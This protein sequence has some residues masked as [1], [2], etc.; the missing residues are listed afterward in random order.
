MSQKYQAYWQQQTITNHQSDE[1]FLPLSHYGVIAVNGADAKTYLQ[2][3][4]SCDVE[5]AD[6]QS[7]LGCCCNVQGRVQAIFRLFRHHDSYYLRLNKTIV[8]LAMNRL[9]KYAIFSKVEINDVSD[10]WYAIGIASSRLNPQAWQLPYS[11]IADNCYELYVTREKLDT[12]CKDS[13]LTVASINSWKHKEFQKK[14]SNIYQDTYEK[15]LPH[16]LNLDKLQG[17]DF[18]KGCYTGQEIIARMHYRGKLKRQLYL[19]NY[20]ANQPVQRND[21]IISIESERAIGHIVD[22]CDQQLLAVID[23]QFIG[24]KLKTQTGN[25]DVNIES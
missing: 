22:Y 20:K 10:Q 5:Q 4:L 7:L 24:D 19:L 16:D 2:G 15:F 3:Q 8:D 12:I 25:I 21:A 13:G 1:F 6:H 18:N 17:I 11:T 9:K 23:K 14:L